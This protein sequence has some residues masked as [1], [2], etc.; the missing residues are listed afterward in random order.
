MTDHEPELGSCCICQGKRGVRN[1]LMLHQKA[2]MPGRGWACLI[3]GLP[4]DGAVAVL[5]DRC[6]EPY[7]SGASRLR[8]VCRGYPD[9]DGRALIGELDPE[10]FDHDMKLHPGEGK[11]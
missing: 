10:P 4:P 8:F 3:C 11:R 1:I 6:M 7:Q 5:C 2:P 9:K